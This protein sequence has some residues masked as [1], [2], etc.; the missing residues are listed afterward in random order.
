MPIPQQNSADD[1]STSARALTG[2]EFKRG[3]AVASEILHGK[4][5]WSKLFEAQNFFQQYEHD[6]ALTAAASAEE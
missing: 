1:V 4:L 5:D 6:T 3:L 2:E